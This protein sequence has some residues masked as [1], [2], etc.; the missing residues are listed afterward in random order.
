MPVTIAPQSRTRS[1]G[2]RN[3][4][5][6]GAIPTILTITVTGS[7]VA[8]IREIT[9]VAEEGAIQDPHKLSVT[10]Q[11]LQEIMGLVVSHRMDSLMVAMGTLA[12]AMLETIGMVDLTQKVTRI[13][14]IKL[15]TT[16]AVNL[17]IQTAKIITIKLETTGAVNLIIQTAKIITIMLRTTGVV[18]LQPAKAR[19]TSR[20]PQDTTWVE[21]EERLK[22]RVKEV[23]AA[24]GGGLGGQVTEARATPG[25]ETVE[26]R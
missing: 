3:A 21:A 22:S 11:A 5:L 1:G 15:E 19:T 17:I 9:G 10:C 25:V 20:T 24:D 8:V 14:T 12:T 6:N 4:Y 13:I 26:P 23:V 16:G 2:A 7:R 18:D